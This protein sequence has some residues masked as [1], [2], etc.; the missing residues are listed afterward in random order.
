MKDVEAICSGRP[1]AQLWREHM[2]L[3]ERLVFMPFGLV[4]YGWSGLLVCALLILDASSITYRVFVGPYYLLTCLWGLALLLLVITVWWRPLKLVY[5]RAA[6]RRQK[7]P[8][9]WRISAYLCI[10]LFAAL[11]FAALTSSSILFLILI[12]IAPGFIFIEIIEKLR[13]QWKAARV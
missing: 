13:E 2:T 8:R 12:L 9:H 6:H 3:D 10:G 4:L 11:L 5:K 1:T 7:L